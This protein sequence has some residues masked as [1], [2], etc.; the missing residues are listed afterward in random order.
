MSRI[1]FAAMALAAF[2][3]AAAADSFAGFSGVDRFYLVAPDRVCKPLEVRQGKATGF[4]PCE[5][6]TSDRIAHLS[7]KT[8]AAERGAKARFV[9]SSSGRALTIRSSDRDVALVEWTGLD[10]IS[11]VDNV[12]GS[13]YG[14]MIAV[15]VVVRRSGR[16][17]TDVL[18]F[19]VGRDPAEPQAEPPAAPVP[20]AVSNAAPEDPRMTDAL[21]QARAVKGKKSIVAW[22]KV[23]AL[24]PSSSEALY[25]T[26]TAQL[27][28]GL[29]ADAMATLGKLAQSTRP[30]AIEYRVAARFDKAFAAVRRD[31]AF[32]AAVG[33]DR[34]ASTTY[35]RVMGFGGQWEQLQTCGKNPGVHLTLARDHAFQLMV[36]SKCSG[37]EYAIKFK[38]TWQVDQAELVLTFPNKGRAVEVARCTITSTLNAGGE[39]ET[40]RCPVDD[41]LEFSVLPVRR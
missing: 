18:A 8:A 16:E 7:I 28:A 32:R 39:E 22:A 29:R 6:A 12:Y 35:E 4:P 36:R 10:P 31:P 9:A 21:R 17:V 23:L 25:G 3:T 24:D 1:L 37:E 11:R 41:D 13:V 27:L 15:E 33:L 40:I 34:P 2:R 20:P 38:G 30:D 19:D 26:A 5:K 14:D